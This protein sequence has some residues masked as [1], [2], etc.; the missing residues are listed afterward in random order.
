[1]SDLRFTGKLLIK[2]D[3][4]IGDINGNIVLNKALSYSINS[5]DICKYICID[6]LNIIRNNGISDIYEIII[7]VSAQS[8]GTALFSSSNTRQTPYVLLRTEFTPTGPTG[9]PGPTGPTGPTGATGP[10]GPQGPQG[11]QGPTGA[12]GIQGPQ[13]AQGPTGATGPQGPQGIQGATGVTG[14]QGPQGLQGVAESSAIIPYASGLP[15]TL[16]TIAGGL[17]GTTA[18]VGFGNS[19]NGVSILGGTI[20]LSGASIVAGTPINMA[21]SA[22]RDGTITAISAY[23]SVTTALSI[24]GTTVTIT[25]Q[26]YR[27]TTPNNTFTAVPGA[28]VT[29]APALTGLLAIGASSN[30]LITGLNIPVT[31]QTRLLLVFSATATGLSLAQTIIGY[32][33]GGVAIS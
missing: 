19:A 10:Q 29:L 22:P 25:A 31:S 13:G 18:L 5:R 14:L 4:I 2:F 3:V 20:D 32:A 1:M 23:F 33:S 30:G 12:T 17:V 9:M 28:V 21:F 8:Q 15:V 26:L 6:L 16:T 27:S 7:N 11:I 24:T